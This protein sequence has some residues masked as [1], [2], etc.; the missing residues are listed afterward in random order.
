MLMERKFAG[1]RHDELPTYGERSSFVV[2]KIV[3]MGFQKM[4]FRNASENCCLEMERQFAFRRF[5]FV[6]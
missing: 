5:T 4:N 6:R 1:R 2:P 3:Q